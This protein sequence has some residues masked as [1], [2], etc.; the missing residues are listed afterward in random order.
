MSALLDMSVGML[1]RFAAVAAVPARR[2][3]IPMGGTTA[4]GVARRFL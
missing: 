3:Q 1:S 2:V 4:A